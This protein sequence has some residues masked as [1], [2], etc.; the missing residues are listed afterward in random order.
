MSNRR[1]WIGNTRGGKRSSDVTGLGRLPADRP[2]LA[3]RVGIAGMSLPVWTLLACV[4]A[5]AAQAAIIENFDSPQG[6]D[7]HVLFRG[8]PLYTVAIGTSTGANV[9]GNAHENAFI[10]SNFFTLITNDQSGSGHFLYHQTVSDG[11]PSYAGEVW[12]TLAA[13]PVTAGQNYAFSFYLT[14]R[15]T[16]A[17]AEIQPLINGSA[18]STGGVSALG[19][20]DDGIATH[21]WQKFSFVWNSGSA[22]TA[23]LS[24]VNLT[25]SGAGNDFALDTIELTEVPGPAAISLLT[26]AGLLGVGRNRR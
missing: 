25:T 12:G 10:L 11:T 4:M 22:T 1:S 17:I 7:G 5:P 26:V 6:A 21:R 15:D 9:N 16:S 13:V 8:D 24:L 20:F 18:V 14:N 2:S 19:S 3:A 23:D